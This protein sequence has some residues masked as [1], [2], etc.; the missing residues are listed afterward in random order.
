LPCRVSPFRQGSLSNLTVAMDQPP[1]RL[2]HTTP[3]LN[4]SMW[5]LCMKTPLKTLVATCCTFCPPGASPS[6]G[7][8]EAPALIAS[9]CRRSSGL[10]CI[11]CFAGL[12]IS[13]PV[14]W[15]GEMDGT[16]VSLPGF[17]SCRKT[18]PCPWGRS[19]PPA[20]PASKFKCWGWLER[21]PT[22]PPSSSKFCSIRNSSSSLLRC[23]DRRLSPCA[24]DM[25]R[26]R[27]PS[28]PGDGDPGQGSG[29]CLPSASVVWSH[30]L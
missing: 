7:W 24:G 2:H 29:A 30:K 15:L 23:L 5:E 28:L 18:S 22:I 13:S 6:G 25:Y 20:F 16:A 26:L 4:H 27:S 14:S 3:L 12:G 19:G 1:Q 8:S 21:P 9:G 11:L 17:R 10:H